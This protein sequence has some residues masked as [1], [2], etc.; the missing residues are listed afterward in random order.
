MRLKKKDKRRNPK[1]YQRCINEIE[2]RRQR[3]ERRKQKP[4]IE[5]YPIIDEINIK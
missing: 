2:E 5:N 1:K 4:R 3:M